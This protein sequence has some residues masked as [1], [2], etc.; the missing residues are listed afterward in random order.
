MFAISIISLVTGTLIL[1]GSA[2]WVFEFG[3]SGFLIG[4][5]LVFTGLCAIFYTIIFK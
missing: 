4:V 5:L 2:F 1:I 3:V